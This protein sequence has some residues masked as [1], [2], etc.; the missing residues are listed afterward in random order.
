MTGGANNN[1]FHFLSGFW[2]KQQETLWGAC[3][4]VIAKVATNCSPAKLP[5]L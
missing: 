5:I 4:F 3:Y 2:V 1:N